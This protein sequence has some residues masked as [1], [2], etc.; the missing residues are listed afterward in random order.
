MI[1]DALKDLKGT[2]STSATFSDHIMAE[3]RVALGQL[4]GSS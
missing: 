2:P 3:I 1:V 4:R